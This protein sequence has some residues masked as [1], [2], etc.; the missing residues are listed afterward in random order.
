MKLE[1]KKNLH[2]FF[3]KNSD[4]N[5]F[6][7]DY[8]EMIGNDKTLGQHHFVCFGDPINDI[9]SDM[10]EE[11]FLEVLKVYMQFKRYNRVLFHSLPT[12]K[13]LIFFCFIFF[14]T[15]INVKFYVVL[16]GGEI[17]HKKT[18]IVQ[19]A[20][21]VL[22]K[23]FLKK[24]TG[25]ITYFEQDYHKVCNFTGN[26]LAKHVNLEGFYPSNIATDNLVPK[27]RTEL[28]VMIGSSALPRNNHL[29]VFK[30]LEV[31][32]DVNSNVVF[33]L[34]LSYGDQQYAE[35]VY[36]N[37]VDLFGSDNVEAH[38]DLMPIE[39]YL[40]LLSTID[41]AIFN[42]KDQQGMGNIRNLLALGCIIYLNRESAS[43]EYLKM[44]GFDVFSY[45]E[46]SL[47]REFSEKNI[48]RAKMLFSEE[49]TL[50]KQRAFFNE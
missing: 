19:K 16:W 35:N 18:G 43:F 4:P 25:F 36:R 21:A 47:T 39:D 27:R 24:A 3:N 12:K 9:R 5:K 11:S 17:Y 8:I 37:A 14:I 29:H 2:I 48:L 32:R 44:L 41:I 33:V 50:N 6:L 22:A 34:P 31:L 40:D 30:K 15:L 49:S 10:V 13:S 26:F 38:F 46:V 1:H 23:Y 7:P 42:H 20:K 28:R 45:E